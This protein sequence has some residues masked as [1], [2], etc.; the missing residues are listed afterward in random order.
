MAIPYQGSPSKFH[1]KL[2][3]I[4]KKSDLRTTQ[5]IKRYASG[6]RMIPKNTLLQ[7]RSRKKDRVWLKMFRRDRL[8]HQLRETEWPFVI[9]VPRLRVTRKS[10][11]IK[12][13]SDFWRIEQIER[14]GSGTRRISK[15]ELQHGRRTKSEAYTKI[16]HTSRALDPSCRSQICRDAIS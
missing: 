9:K 14:Y 15:N 7:E 6:T 5:Q 13:K 4:K 12:R 8:P 16:K 10:Q 3:E 1:E 2:A 11:N